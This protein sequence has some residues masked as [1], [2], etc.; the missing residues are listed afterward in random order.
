MVAGK[1]KFFL[2]SFALFFLISALPASAQWCRVL[3]SDP[4][5]GA[6]D[7]PLTK[8]IT[9][10]F[11]EPLRPAGIS[12]NFLIEMPAKRAVPL[13]MTFSDDMKTIY[14]RPNEPLKRGTYYVVSL[15]GIES[16]KTHAVNK[17]HNYID[18]T[19]VGGQFFC[20][21]YATPSQLELAP[22]GFHDVVY[23][24]VEKGGGW[25][26][27]MRCVQ[28]YEDMSGRELMRNSEQM[29]LIIPDKQ[30]VK[31]SSSISIPADLGNRLKGSTV[32]VRRIFEG[33]DHDNN[34][35]ELRTGVQVRIAIPSYSITSGA[36]PTMATGKLSVLTPQYGA[37]IPQGSYIPIEATIKATPRTAVHGCWIYDGTPMGF[38]ADTIPQN[39]ILRRKIADKLFAAVS[40]IHRVAIQTIS[41]QKATSETLEY[42]VT[43]APMSTTILMQPKH[44]ATF[45]KMVS[46]PPT[47]R[48]SIV[49]S[50]VSYKIYFSTDVAFKKSKIYTSESNQFTPDW[51][52]WGALGEGHI[53][54]R[55][56]PVL[57]GG[58]EGTPSKPRI[59]NIVNN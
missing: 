41:P 28:V 9:I 19:T 1:I 55:V 31:L 22:G 7:V 25:G 32:M 54:W 51:V 23:S 47:F 20:L 2:I 59:I 43:Q 48:W 45:R 5:H 37:V 24:F 40:G 8:V 36:T 29:K 52:K 18:F 27:I 10:T 6:K 14:L 58:T 44:D 4:P 11:S 15:A 38:F 42:I 33:L 57:S 3:S 26:E 53:Y 50:A 49:Q 46:T 56:A 13:S 17:Y 21:A 35:V 39:G 12:S 34:K 30:T 16:A